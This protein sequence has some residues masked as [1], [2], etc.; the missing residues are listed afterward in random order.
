MKQVY[1]NIMNPGYTEFERLEVS[2]QKLII[3]KAYV[4]SDPS[5]HAI[6]MNLLKWSFITFV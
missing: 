5:K 4:W 3:F 6:S 1:R 2:L